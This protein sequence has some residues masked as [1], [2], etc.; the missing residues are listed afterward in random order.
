MYFAHFFYRLCV[1]KWLFAFAARIILL[2]DLVIKYQCSFGIPWI[3]PNVSFKQ[4]N[5]VIFILL[6]NAINEFLGFRKIV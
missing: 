5:S 3:F 4:K 1:F 6:L 2:P